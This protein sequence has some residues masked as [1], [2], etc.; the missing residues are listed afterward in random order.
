MDSQKE[1]FIHDMIK[2][3]GVSKNTAKFFIELLE[4]FKTSDPIISTSKK[5]AIVF[6]CSDRTIQRYVKEL[7]EEFNYIH[8]K[9][10]WN[11][12]NPDRPYIES[13]TYSRTE[14]A[15]RLE[16][17]AE[18]FSVRDKNVNFEAGLF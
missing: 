17:R 11:N 9:P 12:D 10:K 18:G 2:A 5:L 7:K 4:H 13:N 6:K 14:L 3:E 8:V 15:L 16:K 1:R